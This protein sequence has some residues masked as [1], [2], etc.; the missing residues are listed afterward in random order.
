[1]RIV[2]VSNSV[3][4]SSANTKLHYA[5]R[6]QNVDSKIIVLSHSGE[7][8]ETYNLEKSFWG[9]I[10]NI[11]KDKLYYLRY[12]KINTK[13]GFPFSI[14]SKGYPLY[15][16]NLL[17]SA[18]VIHL[19]WICGI[20]SIKDIQK[21]QATGKPMI[22]TCHDSWPFTGG[23]HVRYGCTK[24]MN[25]CGQ[26]EM[27]QS[28]KSHDHS[29]RVMKRKMKLLSNSHIVFVAPSKWIMESIK[30]SAIFSGNQVINIPNAI[31]I[32]KFKPLNEIEIEEEIG[33]NKWKDN[34]NILFGA[35]DTKTPYKGYN[36]LIKALKL[37]YEKNKSF[38]K[39]IV[40]HI[41]GKSEKDPGIEDMFQC[42]YWG[43]VEKTEKLAAIYNIADFMLYPSLDDNLPNMVMESM[44]CA[45]PVIAFRTGGIPDM[46]NHKQNGFLASY[47]DEKEMVEGID[48]MFNNNQENKLGRNAREKVINCYS[49]EKIAKQHIELYESLLH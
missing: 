43:Y 13:Y 38:T 17:K 21:L 18:D 4:Y 36:Y 14:G 32:Y 23:C 8:T 15:K 27:I 44:A 34:I 3:S 42:V 11:L 28:D 5:L 41:V 16:N 9:K 6:K 2:H 19:H 39:Q 48:W 12:G 7:I 1:M 31:N 49:E 47:K 35:G 22:W 45:T 40:L 29:Y 26:C 24:Y 20:L 30:N 33:T 46:I 37:L 25:T 10:N